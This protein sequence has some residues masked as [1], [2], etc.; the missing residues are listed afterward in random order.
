MITVSYVEGDGVVDDRLMIGVQLPDTNGGNLLVNGM[1]QVVGAPADYLT[2]ATLATP[3]APATGVIYWNVQVDP[4]T[5]GG[6]PSI[7]QSISAPPS[8]LASADGN[9]AHVQRI[10]YSMMLTPTTTDPALD[11]NASSPDPAVGL[12]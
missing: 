2:G 8:A 6:T 10:V 12:P 1:I 5:P 7:Q 9:P 3:S 4:Y 11:P